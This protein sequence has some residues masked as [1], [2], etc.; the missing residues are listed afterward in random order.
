MWYSTPVNVQAFTQD[1]SFQM[2]NA[3]GNGM[4]FTIQNSGT[5]AL[6]YAGA[7]LGYGASSPG[8]TLGIPNSV[9]VKFDL[10]NGFG[11]G[12]NSTGL[13][14]DGASPTVPAIDLT[15]SG[16]NLHSGDVMNVHMTYDGATLRM[17]LTDSVT[18]AVFSTSWPI[19]IPGTVGAPTAYVGFTGATGAATAIQDVLQWTFVSPYT[20]S[21]LQGF[22][23]TGLALNGNAALNRK[24]IR[25]TDGDQSEI[26]SAWF[27]TPVNVQSF[28]AQFSFQPTQAVA[29]GMTFTIQSAGPTAFGPG[30]A[31]LGYGASTLDGA[32][33]IPTSVAIKFDLYDNFG[34]GVDSV[35]L[36]T[37]GAS[38]TVPAIDLTPSG[39]NLHSGDPFRVHVTYD[40]HTLVMRITDKVTQATFLTSWRINIPATLNSNTGYV[41]FT[42]A[43]GAAT[44]IQDV[45]TLIYIH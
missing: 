6:G 34:E 14:T 12:D 36:Y 2:T 27:S 3:V 5:T 13:Y 16:V 15:P 1:F 18:G 25:L 40:G 11:E 21:Y 23:P 10:Y 31:G 35:G 29:D 9:A 7:G 8:G 44:S 41:G 4:T 32:P 17:T 22:T 39:V 38:P 20:I 19:D 30:G 33:G 45:L 43:T 42:G 37:N 28:D 26:S 24:K